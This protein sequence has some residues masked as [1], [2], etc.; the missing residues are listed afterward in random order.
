MLYKHLLY[1]HRPV[2]LRGRH[3]RSHNAEG[4]QHLYHRCS[5]A[6]LDRWFRDSLGACLSMPAASAETK[7][8][9]QDA[10]KEELRSIS[11]SDNSH[12]ARGIGTACMLLARGA[13]KSQLP[14]GFK[15]TMEA[16]V[17]LTQ[18][19]TPDIRVRTR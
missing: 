13:S 10:L 19:N 12:V 6:S 16:V 15:R 11:S 3:S 7:L 17:D 2:S 9:L 1:I 8:N 5:D 14:A 18:S 4:T